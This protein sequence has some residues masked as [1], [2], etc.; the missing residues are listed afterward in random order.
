[1]PSIH[2]GFEYDIFI[3]YRQNDNQPTQGFGG[4]ASDGWVT[5]F[6]EALK[7]ELEAALKTSVSIYFD[8]NPHDGLLETHQVDA[9]LAKKLKCLVFIPIISQTYCDTGSFAW[10]HEFMPFIDMAKEDEMGMNI[11]LSNGNV[12][13]RVLP[14]KIHR[15][16]SEDQNTLESVLDGPLRAI[17]FIYQ[18][19]GVNR[20]L[21]PTDKRELNLE[22]TDYRNQVNKVAN[23]LKDIGSSIIKRSDG[24]VSPPVIKA[25]ELPEFKSTQKRV[26]YQALAA[27]A[28]ALLIYW[29]YTKFY[30]SPAAQDEDVTIAV[31]AFDDQSPNGDQ[32]WLGDGMADEIL[33]VL[34]KVDGLQVTG[35]TS[36][37]SFKGKGQTTK[38]I[39][40]T[41][42]VSAV[43]EGS[44]SK[45]GNKL[46]ITAQLIDVET[47]AHIWSK[48]YDR[49]ATDIFNIIDEVAQSIA[50][51]LRSEL[52]IAEKEKIKTGRSVNPEAYEYYLKG[53]YLHWTIFTNSRSDD[54]FRQA[55]KMFVKAIALDST[56]ADAYAGL[57]D[58]YDT[59]AWRDKSYNRK[60]DSVV[61]IA[62]RINPNSA[63]VLL[64]KGLHFRKPDSKNIDSAFFY[65]I[66]AHDLDPTNVIIDKV[67]SDIYR[68]LG[69]YEQA[70]HFSRKIIKSDPLDLGA[71]YQL[72]R[73]LA[74]TGKFDEAKE[75]FEKILEVNPNHIRTN[76]FMFELAIFYDKDPKEAAIILEKLQSMLPNDSFN[77]FRSWL[78]AINGKKEEALKLSP[79]VFTYALLDMKEEAM[80]MVASWYSDNP[81]IGVNTYLVSL[82]SRGL[83][84]L[85]EEPRFKEILAE[86]KKVYEERLTKYGHLFDDE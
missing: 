56:Y 70:I 45:I 83:K 12:T 17:D 68:Y 10:E 27:I 54:D 69:L 73:S 65:Y 37:F 31:L 30:D 7:A 47:D 20:P 39:G 8:E 9:S 32:E 57:A 61:N 35:K 79:Y 42:N 11:T 48:K 6:V 67:I 3:S 74:L 81:N 43:L 44:V 58:L 84:F 62:Y 23:A 40:E 14:I 51:A 22:K 86:Q 49:D 36:S 85:R 76:K 28:I 78:L 16:D 25:D 38:V 72:A 50:G 63:Y 18:E 64:T 52:S 34:A 5:N 46:R 21:L 71:R 26:I 53:V 4:Q 82:N 41:L 29:G 60:R 77:A 75:E 15:L 59:K 33:N 13:S 2:A 80:T 66:K 55:E 19:A 1:M 24:K